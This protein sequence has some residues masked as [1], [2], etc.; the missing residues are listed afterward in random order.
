MGILTPREKTC[1][2]WVAVGKTSREI[3]AMLKISART[4]D[5]HIN[6]ACSKFSVNNRH[7][8]VTMALKYKQIPDIS[9]LLPPLKPINKKR[10]KSEQSSENHHTLDPV[11]DKP[12]SPVK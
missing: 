3:A 2:S 12:G 9:H 4:V 11:R 10:K 1:M 7:S 6:N 5:Y 8:A